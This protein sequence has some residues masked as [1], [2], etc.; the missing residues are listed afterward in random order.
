MKLSE[1]FVNLKITIRIKG[2][3]QRETQMERGGN[4]RVECHLNLKSLAFGLHTL[5]NI[6]L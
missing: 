4:L 3:H 1:N 2:F 6:T 5:C